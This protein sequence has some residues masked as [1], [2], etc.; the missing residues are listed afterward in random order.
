[1]VS[2]WLQSRDSP[3]AAQRGKREFGSD[4]PGGKAED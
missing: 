3:L 4:S 1:M 2:V